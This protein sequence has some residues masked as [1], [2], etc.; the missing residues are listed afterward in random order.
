LIPST[1]PISSCSNK[2]VP[3]TGVRVLSTEVAR[4][5]RAELLAVVEQGTGRRVRE[6]LSGPDGRPLPIGGKTGTGD[7]QVR[8]VG[9]TVSKGCAALIAA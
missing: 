4:A 1:S 3:D 8:A 2:P 6:A 7:N 5:V 9:T